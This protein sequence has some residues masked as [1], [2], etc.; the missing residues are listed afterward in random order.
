M[1]FFKRISDVIKANLDDIL[2]K[3][4][5]QNPEAVLNQLI[6]E[7]EQK[8][9]EARQQIL[10]AKTDE[11]MLLKRYQVNQ[12]KAKEWKQKAE[13]ALKSGK[14]DLAKEALM[15]KNTHLKMAE[16]FKKQWENQKLNVE[17]LHL[18][19]EALEAKVEEA[20]R[21]KDILVARAKRAKAQEKITSTIKNLDEENPFDQF[22]KMS[23]KIESLEAQAEAVEEMTKD[24]LDKEF[25]KLEAQFGDTDIDSELEAMKKKL[26]TDGDN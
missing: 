4:E 18:G 19:L 20:K 8:V 11:K 9:R 25:K 12:A 14:E 1:G 17:K 26:L 3:A 15:R 10:Q 5:D 23:E 16:E 2:S 21:E 7:M 24:D 22:D 6:N 13:F